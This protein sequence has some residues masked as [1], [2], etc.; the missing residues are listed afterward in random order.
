MTQEALLHIVQSQLAIDM[1]CAIDD[2]NG[3]KDSILF[4]Q[5]RE[6]LGRR[7][8]PRSERHFEILSMGR[9]IIVSASPDILAI[10]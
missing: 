7:P 2:L 4:T 10:V 1:N 5:A 3:E 8:F 6:N 9:A